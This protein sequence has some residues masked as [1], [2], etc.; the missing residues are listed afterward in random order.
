MCTDMGPFPSQ[1]INTPWVVYWVTPTCTGAFASFELWLLGTGGAGG[2]GIKP[3]LL[4][5]WVVLIVTPPK[6]NQGVMTNTRSY[7]PAILS[8]TSPPPSHVIIKSWMGSVVF[9][10]TTYTLTSLTRKR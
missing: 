4:I 6:T 10:V 2:T 3:F 1:L 8:I 5:G 7:C 9:L